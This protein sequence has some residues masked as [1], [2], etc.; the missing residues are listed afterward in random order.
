MKRVDDLRSKVRED[1]VGF[2][3]IV[4]VEVDRCVSSRTASVICTKGLSNE[5]VEIAYEIQRGWDR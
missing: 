3:R 1:S 5:I 2:R 4:E